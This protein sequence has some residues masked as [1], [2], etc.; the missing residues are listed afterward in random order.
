[1]KKYSLLLLTVLLVTFSIHS[2]SACYLGNVKE[3]NYSHAP[4][5]VIAGPEDIQLP[6]IQ[7]HYLS[8]YNWTTDSGSCAWSS[9]FINKWLVFLFLLV[10]I[11]SILA[12]LISRRKK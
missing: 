3:S 12:V 10:T 9:L 5:F 6:S 11:S 2:V 4:Y 8:V 1:M 7:S